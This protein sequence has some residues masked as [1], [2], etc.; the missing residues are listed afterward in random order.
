M[1]R[2]TG[3]REED[4]PSGAAQGGHL[5]AT[6][7]EL[8]EG[9]ECPSQEVVVVTVV[10][11]DLEF[12]PE[13]TQLRAQARSA[14]LETTDGAYAST[15]ALD[16]SCSRLLSRR[17]SRGSRPWLFALLLILAAVAT[18]VF[19]ALLGDLVHLEWLL[20][21]SQPYFFTLGL[22]LLLIDKEDTNRLRFYVSH[23]LLVVA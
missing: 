3:I 21:C 19:P 12:T 13:K 22:G 18:L 5:V 17:C 2:V 6:A 9:I 14:A 7:H 4:L 16:P 1:L 15:L 23:V 11:L 20:R 10:L 8:A